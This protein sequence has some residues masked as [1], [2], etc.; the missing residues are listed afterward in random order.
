M[1]L[2][3]SD[4]MSNSSSSKLFKYCYD[5]VHRDGVEIDPLSKENVEKQTLELLNRYSFLYE[6]A[7]VIIF[8]YMLSCDCRGDIFKKDAKKIKNAILEY[9]LL[10]RYEA[11]DTRDF[12]EFLEIF[13]EGMLGYETLEDTTFYKEIEGLK[14]TLLFKS[15]IEREKDLII[16]SRAFDNDFYFELVLRM[17]SAF[18]DVQSNSTLINNKYLENIS[19][20]MML[21]KLKREVLC[22]YYDIFSFINDPDKQREYGNCFIYFKP[23][24]CTLVS[25]NEFIGAFSGGYKC[26]SFVS[27]N[28]N[29]PSIKQIKDIYFKYHDELPCD[30]EIECVSDEDV[31]KPNGTSSCGSKFNVREEDIFY[32][33]GSFYHLCGNCGY[34]VKVPSSL[35][36][37]VIKERIIKRCESDSLLIRKRELLSELTSLDKD[38][39]VLIKSRGE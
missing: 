25:Y 29:G 19:S 15:L 34:I 33:N 5:F 10:T 36:K 8:Y 11:I 30:L 37:D 21:P 18:I 9:I 13:E 24:R 38:Y 6:N 20:N 22:R 3:Y 31:S 16:E 7:K 14:S 32:I 1:D 27:N 23:A 17:L 12:N 35:L 39:K 2:E 28:D 4:L 26:R